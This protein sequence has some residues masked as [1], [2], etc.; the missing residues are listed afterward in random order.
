MTPALLAGAKRCIRLEW[1]EADARAYQAGDLVEVWDHSPR[2]GGQVVATIRITEPVVWAMMAETPA[3]DYEAEGWAWMHTHP[4][5]AP[6][7][8]F[9]KRTQRQAFTRHRF[10]AWRAQPYGRWVLRFTLV[11]VR[12]LPTLARSP[13][14]RPAP[15]L[16][17]ARAGGQ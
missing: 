4:R 7:R 1:D 6:S 8:V 16:E 2:A 12:E 15:D 5:A 9:G 17:P 11:R 13:G 14:L 3:T 10:D